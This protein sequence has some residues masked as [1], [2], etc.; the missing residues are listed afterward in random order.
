MDQLLKNMAKIDPIHD[1][2]SALVHIT[3]LQLKDVLYNMNT[4]TDSQNVI[5]AIYPQTKRQSKKSGFWWCV[6]SQ[7]PWLIHKERN[8]YKFLLASIVSNY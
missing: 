1:E 7:T 2:A 8:G 4:I 3:L 6:L 5:S